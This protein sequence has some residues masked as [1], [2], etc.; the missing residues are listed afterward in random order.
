MSFS[1]PFF[2]SLFSSP[3]EED[4]V[5]QLKAQSTPTT[6]KPRDVEIVQELIFKIVVIGGTAVGKTSVIRR[7]CQDL[8]TQ[9]YAPTI[10]TSF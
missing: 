10:G 5:K 8:F 3:K 1:I 6:T 2:G 7:F 4:K 9:K